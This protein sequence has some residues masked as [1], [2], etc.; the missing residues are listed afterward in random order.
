MHIGQVGGIGREQN[1]QGGDAPDNG[2]D[3]PFDE[4]A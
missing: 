4:E 1:A 2:D 3:R